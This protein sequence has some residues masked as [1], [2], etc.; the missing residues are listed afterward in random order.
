MCVGTLI[1]LVS[2]VDVILEGVLGALGY[3]Y[4]VALVMACVKEIKEDLDKYLLWREGNNLKP[5]K[6]LELVPVNQ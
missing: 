5:E 6:G 2:P 4:D 3:L 1:Y